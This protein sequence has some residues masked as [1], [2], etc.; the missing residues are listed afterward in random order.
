MT[1]VLVE[2]RLFLFFLSLLSLVGAARPRRAERDARERA[3]PEQSLEAAG[4]RRAERRHRAERHHEAEERPPRV[5]VRRRANRQSLRARAIVLFFSEFIRL[6]RRPSS[7]RAQGSLAAGA[8]SRKSP[9]LNSPPSLRSRASSLRPN[10]PAIALRCG[11]CTHATRRSCKKETLDLNKS[12][13]AGQAARRF[14]SL[15]S[16]NAAAN[17]SAA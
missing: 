8:P 11:A 14:W 4:A 9:A 5:R 2:K 10:S 15:W 3:P 6:T 1:R 13:Y 16:T 12:V 17:I 7:L